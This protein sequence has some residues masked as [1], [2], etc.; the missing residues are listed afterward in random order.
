[1][2]GFTEG[3]PVEAKGQLVRGGHTEYLI[4]VIFALSIALPSIPFPSPCLCVAL[5]SA[6]FM[7]PQLP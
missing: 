1:M 5:C 2:A 7:Q 4:P 6:D 3:H